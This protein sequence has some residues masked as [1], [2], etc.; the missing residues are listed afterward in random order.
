MTVAVSWIQE[1]GRNLGP[2]FQ[3]DKTAWP[4]TELE[5]LGIELDSMKMEAR[6]P[7]DKFLNSWSSQS[8][9]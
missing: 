6:L 9:Y 8:A 7:D 2:I 4:T 5:F 3:H 1:L